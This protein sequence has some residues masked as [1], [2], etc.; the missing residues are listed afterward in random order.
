METKV[1]DI[2][3]E[4]G[5][6]IFSVTPATTVFDAIRM[7]AEKD[8]GAILVMDGDKL[9]GIFTERDYMKKIILKGLSSK[10]TQVN[11]VM[12][13]KMA[14]ITPESSLEEGLAVMAEK[15]CR[16]LPVFE[17]KKLAGLISIGDLAQR[18]IKDQK[19]TINNLAEYIAGHW[20][21]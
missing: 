5:Q 7:M 14:Y 3:K 6:K 20:E 18:I 19:I 15:N 11:S 4:R 17:N 12:T 1:E 10:D 9:E 16:H 13:T 8:I 21:S 2:L